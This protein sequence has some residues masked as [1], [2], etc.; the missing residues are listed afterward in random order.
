MTTISAVIYPD[1]GQWAANC[2]EYDIGA[3]APSIGLLLER[4]E[5]AILANLHE[6]LR[7]SG[8]PFGGIDPAPAPHET[9]SGES[10]HL[11]WRCFL[12]YFI[13]LAS[14]F[15]PVVSRPSAKSAPMW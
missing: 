10:R 7:M 4:L 9:Q 5:A 11:R 3:Q 14:A 12:M 6:S 15:G 8:V 2:I 1:G 13:I